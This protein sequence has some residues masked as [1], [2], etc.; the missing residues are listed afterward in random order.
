M[1]LLMAHN[2]ELRKS[3]L[4]KREFISDVARFH[5]SIASYCLVSSSTKVATET[6]TMYYLNPTTSMLSL[7]LHESEAKP[8]TS[9][10]NN[11]NLRV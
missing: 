6:L 10:N 7:I 2:F 5:P 9:V 1:V 4:T 3:R 11:D 8:R